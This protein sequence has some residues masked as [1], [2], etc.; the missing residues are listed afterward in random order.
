MEGIC[1]YIYIS[2]DLA[3]PPRGG[4][5]KVCGVIADRTL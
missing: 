5:A 1:D 2:L 3:P 4:G